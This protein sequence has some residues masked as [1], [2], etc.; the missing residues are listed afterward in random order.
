MVLTNTNTRVTIIYP[1]LLLVHSL[2][3][4]DDFTGERKISNN[5]NKTQ[6][7]RKTIYKVKLGTEIPVGNLTSAKVHPGV[8]SIS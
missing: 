7:T 4:F 2:L 3:P 8:L 6:L 5:N 1:S